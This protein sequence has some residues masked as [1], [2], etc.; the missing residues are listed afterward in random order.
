MPPDSLAV[1]R[2]A[3]KIAPATSSPNQREPRQIGPSH[4]GPFFLTFVGEVTTERAKETARG[5]SSMLGH[6]LVNRKQLF[7]HALQVV[8]VQG[9]GSIGFRVRR[10]VVDLEED[11][12]HPC[13]D[14]SA[15]KH[16]DELGLAA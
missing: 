11:S 13:R 3:A 15:G 5:G 6:C 12:V 8:Q 9:V 16:G 4:E 2:R 14:G 10:I 7:Q 1:R